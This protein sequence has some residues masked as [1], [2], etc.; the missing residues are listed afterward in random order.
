MRDDTGILTR[1]HNQLQAIDAIHGLNRILRLSAGM[2][3]V[4][5]EM[6]N[7]ASSNSVDKIAGLAFP[8]LS[9]DG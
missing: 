7:R 2:F 8:L 9:T 6:Q 1:F 5:S 4:L 3:D